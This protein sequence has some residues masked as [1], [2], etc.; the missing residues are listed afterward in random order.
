LGERANVD[1]LRPRNGGELHLELLFAVTLMPMSTRFLIEFAQ[2]RS[3]LLAYWANIVM[4]GGIL[5]PSWGS[6]DAG[7]V[8]QG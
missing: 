4:L 7:S 2:L 6:C 8:D 3:A 1:K 5:Y